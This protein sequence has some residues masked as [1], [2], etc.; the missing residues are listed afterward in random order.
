MANGNKMKAGKI[1][2]NLLRLVSMEKTE[3]WKDVTEPG[4][5]RYISKAEAL[6]RT[7]YKMA[8]GYSEERERK[9]ED[10]NIV[11]YTTYIAP[12]RHLLALIWERLEGKV[13]TAE[14]IEERRAKIADR[15][16]EEG[17]KRIAAAGGGLNEFSDGDSEADA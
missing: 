11:K 4:D 14:E 2:N 1:L 7:A 16:S 6:V 10:G 5:D 15:V 17:K 12:D 9:T 3:F 8:L 13:S